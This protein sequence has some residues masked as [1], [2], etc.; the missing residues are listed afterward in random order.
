MPQASSIPGSARASRLR[1]VK[2]TVAGRAVSP[3]VLVHNRF[4]AAGVT[5]P[6]TIA[7]AVQ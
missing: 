7:V 2:G 5:P 3:A 1:I 4:Q 6:A